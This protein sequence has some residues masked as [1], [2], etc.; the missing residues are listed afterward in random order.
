MGQPETQ[1]QSKDVTF[2]ALWTTGRRTVLKT[3]TRPPTTEAQAVD[4]PVDEVVA[5]AE[6]LEEAVEAEEVVVDVAEAETT[7]ECRPPPL[8]QSI[9]ALSLQPQ[10]LHRP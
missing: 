5:E 2:V 4:T 6:P 3:P 10:A 7:A 8:S 9:G 1:G